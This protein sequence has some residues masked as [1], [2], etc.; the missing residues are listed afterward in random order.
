MDMQQFAELS[1]VKFGVDKT[2]PEGPVFYT[3][4]KD[5]LF[6]FSGFASKAE[7]S[8]RWALDTFGQEA[9]SG[10]KIIMGAL[11]ISEERISKILSLKRNPS[12][13]QDHLL[14]LAKKYARSYK[15]SK[16][17]SHRDSFMFLEKDLLL[18]SNSILLSAFP[19]PYDD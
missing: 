1:G 16:D 8:E 17:T 19:P 7:A 11:K 6:K 10:L 4:A 2:N 18:F 15:K 3:I 14:D 12:F 5:P 9:T 13:T